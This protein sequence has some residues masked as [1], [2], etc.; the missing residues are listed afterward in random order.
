MPSSS[1]HHR[2]N[3]AWRG[4]EARDTCISLVCSVRVLPMTY[5]LS[6]AAA[7]AVTSD[8]GVAT[9]PR[10]STLYILSYLFMMGILRIMQYDSIH[11]RNII[12]IIRLLFFST[13]NAI[14]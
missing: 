8:N 11:T 7:A 4:T 14:T 9:Y 6:A 2:Y 5:L 10:V 13:V 3:A 12:N 1:S